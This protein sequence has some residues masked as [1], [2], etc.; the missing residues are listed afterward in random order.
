MTVDHCVSC[1][2]E[3][4][5]SKK[6]TLFSV[7]FRPSHW[8][9]RDSNSVLLKTLHHTTLHHVYRCS[10][11]R[12]TLNWHLLPLPESVRSG[13]DGLGTMLSWQG[14]LSQR[15][16]IHK[17]APLAQ[18][19]VTGTTSFVACRSVIMASN[20]R[21][22]FGNVMGVV[23]QRIT[24]K[25]SGGTRIPTKRI[26]YETFHVA[27]CFMNKQLDAFGSNTFLSKYF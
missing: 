10:G 7:L 17:V 8:C 16:H 12:S 5:T 1:T 14:S 13:C 21:S 4:R 3:K 15:Q 2:A 27:Q 26:L 6:N 18:T 19:S 22:I 9:E 23:F 20:Q 24:R 11:F 25:V